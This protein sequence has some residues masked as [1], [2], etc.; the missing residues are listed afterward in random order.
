MT[1]LNLVAKD[2]GQKRILE[3]LQ[4]N[5]SETLAEKINK[6]VHVT[7]DGK[8][9]I[10]V[11]ELSGFMVYAAGEA[12]KLCE[13]GATSACIDGET[14]CG[15]AIHYFEEDSIHG[16]LFNLDGTEYKKE[17]PKI[18]PKTTITKTTIT[19]KPEPKDRQISIFDFTD[20]DSS[21]QTEEQNEP[22]RGEENTELE[23]IADVNT[24][25]AQN[26]E[27]DEIEELELAQ[28]QIKEVADNHAA[29]EP[30]Y[31]RYYELKREYMDCIV[32]YK[33][34]DFYEFYDND[35]EIAADVLG[36]TLTGKYVAKNKRVPLAGIPAYVIDT[37]LIKLSAKYKVL[38]YDCEEEQYLIENGWQ[39]DIATG[40]VCN[41]ADDDEPVAV[42]LQDEETNPHIRY[43]QSIIKDLK[44]DL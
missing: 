9:L 18:I 27:Q 32:C 12:R 42:Q 5:V 39:T 15:W 13:K 43:L 38:C 8:E 36:L 26:E 21:K 22:E 20:L 19:A 3:Y 16:K 2:E 17:T 24:E 35:A 14:V 23:E 6:G 4:E 29:T 34:G 44:V 7:V 30:Y 37:Y 10:S 28:E 1:E 33:L 40:Y 31:K 41:L 25:Q 11:K